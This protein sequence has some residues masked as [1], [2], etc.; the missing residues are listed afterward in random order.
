VSREPGRRRLRYHLCLMPASI[1]EERMLKDAE[2]QLQSQAL[3][4]DSRVYRAKTRPNTSFSRARER[5][6]KEQERQKRRGEGERVC[7][8]D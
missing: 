1:E 5:E 7:E 4:G 2:S 3:R 8:R 6:W